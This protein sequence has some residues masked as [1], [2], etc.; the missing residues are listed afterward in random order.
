MDVALT[1]ARLS[2]FRSS[3]RPPCRR[4]SPPAASA[5]RCTF[6]NSS[7]P[8]SATRICGRPIIG[9]PRNSWP[10]TRAGLPSIT[11]VQP[12][13]VAAW[14]EASARARRL[15]SSSAT[16]RGAICSIGRSMAMSSIPAVNLPAPDGAKVLKLSIE[17]LPVGAHASVA[18]EP[19]IANRLSGEFRS[20]LTANLSP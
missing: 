13:H 12:V 1:F 6:S 3:P 2:A 16:R 4:S 5:P 15:R 7:R 9:R 18:D 8:T 14:I 17:G 11:A 19:F 20:Y 10:G